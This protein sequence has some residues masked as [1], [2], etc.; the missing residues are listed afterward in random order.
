V[1]PPLPQSVLATSSRPDEAW[2]EST[3]AQAARRS[4]YVHA[5]RSLQEPLLAAFDQ[6]DTDNSCP[7]RFATV[8]ATQALILLNGDFA[9][10]QAERFA[11]RLRA[12]AK[13][14]ASQL[15]LGLALVT[16]RKALAAD[17]DRLLELA[18]D[19]QKDHGKSADEALQRCCLVLL[20]SNQ[21]LYLD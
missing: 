17:R 15:E 16:Q 14:L 11:Q 2:G 12:Q 10:Q 7:V 18:A 21:F 8:Q 5:K 19:L 4:L 20:N 13:G 1:F 9:Q 6:A 3:P